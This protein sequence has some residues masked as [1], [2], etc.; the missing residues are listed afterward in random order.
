[1]IEVRILHRGADQVMEI[2][3]ELRTR[4]LVQGVDFDFAYN[5]S[6]WDEM[7]GEV[8]THTLF[9]FYKESEA[10]LFALKYGF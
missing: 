8:P 9:S 2:V 5:Q 6:R 4:G 3:R 7:I 1:M 10:T